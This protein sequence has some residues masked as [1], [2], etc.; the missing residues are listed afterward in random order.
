[1]AKN[2]EF[3]PIIDYDEDKK[4]LFIKLD[5]EAKESIRTKVNNP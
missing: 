4:H 1:M 3:M 2:I 5:K